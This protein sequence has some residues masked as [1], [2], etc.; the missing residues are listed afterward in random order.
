MRGR[1][2]RALSAACA[3]AALRGVRPCGPPR[4]P[5]ACPPRGARMLADRRSTAASPGRCPARCPEGVRGEGA[6]ATAPPVPPGCVGPAEA[7]ACTASSLSKKS[8]YDSC[9]E[10]EMINGA[11]RR[12]QSQELSSLSSKL[13]EMEAKWETLYTQ[14]QEVSTCLNIAAGHVSLLTRVTATAGT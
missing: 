1:T 13:R 8:E 9:E 11:E 10:L 3:G 6:S 14:H 5:D 12:E 2:V 4:L 7:E